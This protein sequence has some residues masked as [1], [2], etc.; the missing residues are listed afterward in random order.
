M[1]TCM[2]VTCVTCEQ[3]ID[4]RIGY[5]NRRIQPL[6]FSCP[7][8]DSQLGITLDTSHAPESRFEFDGC[9][10]SENQPSGPFAGH[11]PFLDLHLDF[12]VREG[13]YT[14]GRTPFLMAMNDLRVA[15]GG[16]DEKA[17]AML[18]H[19]NFHL[20]VLNEI[21]E[22]TGEIKRIINLYLGKNKQLF[23][24]RASEFLEMAENKSLLPQD[25]NATLY[26]VISKAFFPF[27]V[28][29]HSKEISTEMPWLFQRIEQR[30]LGQ[31][32]ND[33]DS[34]NF[35]RELQRDCL[36][37][38]P[39]IIDAELPLRPALFLD[40]TGNTKA[41]KTATRVSAQDFSGLKDLYKDVVEILSRQLVLVAGINNLLYRGDAN[42]FKPIDGRA[43]SDLNKFS[44]K[45]LSD[46]FKYLDDCWFK[47][48]MNA[49]N[50]DLRNAIAHN[51]VNYSGVDQVVTYCP[52]GGRLEQSTVRTMTFLELMRLLLV[53]FREMHSLHHVIKSIFY[54]KYLVH[55]KNA[56]K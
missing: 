43:L 4:C 8:C 13:M 28:F 5:S 30:K 18:M 7:H 51:N 54:Y 24:K 23:Q 29:A 6:V 34:S 38:Y 17:H 31:F 27:T 37:I 25:V 19:H 42:S 15:A 3:Q 48:D 41:E 56:M 11:N 36:K 12:P 55:D 21:T 44:T 46:K 2:A 47:I 45:T 14:I 26:C 49:Y 52:S 50:L 9:A 40:L 39:R 20:N 35:L 22:R 1:N 32:I 10:Q 53:A 16:D 33:I